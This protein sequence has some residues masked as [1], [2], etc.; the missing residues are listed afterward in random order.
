MSITTY[1]ELKT[2]VATWLH[3][4]DLTSN[5]DDLITVG[6]KWIFRKART[7]DMEAALS[8][9]IASGVIAVPAD[10]V[11]LKHAYVSSTSPHIKLSPVAESYIYEAYPTRSGSAMPKF[12]AVSGANFIFGPYGEGY[13]VSGRYYKRLTAVSS[14]ANAL[15]TNNPDLY[16]FAALCEAEP[17]MKNDDRIAMWMAKRNEILEMV[18]SEDRESRS[19]D[20]MRIRAA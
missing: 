9:T 14:S 12:I 4:A 16:L 18:N 2:A 20:G 3:R 15:F 11:A 5:L 1:G 8:G 10:Y 6:E 13:S 19:G 7:R 17:F